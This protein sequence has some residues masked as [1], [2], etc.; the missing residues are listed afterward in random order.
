MKK[1]LGKRIISGVTSVLLGLSAF[2]QAVPLSET[3]LLRARAV[4]ENPDGLPTLTVPYENSIWYR[5]GPLGVA[6]DFHYFAFD[7]VS[8]APHTNGNFAAKHVLGGEG[9]PNQYIGQIVSVV[10]ESWTNIGNEA[11]LKNVPDVVIPVDYQAYGASDVKL[12]Y[13]TQRY[14]F[15]IYRPDETNFT[16]SNGDRDASIE[17]SY[18]SHYSTDFMDFDKLRNYYRDLSQNY[19]SKEDNVES[20]TTDDKG[21]LV[22]KLNPSGENVVNLSAEDF[23]KLENN[24]IHIEGINASSGDS[25]TGTVSQIKDNQYLIMNIDM[26]SFKGN[27][28]ILSKLS[29][30]MKR[31]TID[32]PNSDMGANG[33]E[34]FYQGTNILVNL[35]N[36][37][38]LNNGEP[39]LTVTVGNG[40]FQTLAPDIHLRMNCTNGNGIAEDITNAGETHMNFFMNPVSKNPETSEIT[41][42]TVEKEW[43]DDGKEHGDKDAVTVTLYRSDEPNADLSSL[44]DSSALVT[45][46][47]EAFEAMVGD[48]ALVKDNTVVG[49]GFGPGFGGGFGGGQSLPSISVLGLQTSGTSIGEYDANKNVLMNDRT[50]GYGLYPFEDYSISAVETAY[51]G[52]GWDAELV[53]KAYHDLI[54]LDE[55]NG[56]IY[57]NKLDYDLSQTYNNTIWVCLPVYSGWFADYS[58]G[59]KATITE[60]TDADGNTIRKITKINGEPG[61]VMKIG[62]AV[63]DTKN[64]WQNTWND[65]PA[66]SATGT[67]Y[68][69]YAIE[70]TVKKDYTVSYKGNSMPGGADGTIIVVNTKEE[71]HPPAGPSEI[72]IKKTD[73][74]GTNEVEGAEFKLTISGNEPKNF[75]GVK[76][77]TVDGKGKTELTFS[78]SQTIKGLKDGTYVLE[79]KV[80]PDGYTVVSKF[81][82][83]LSEGKVTDTSAVTSGDV[84]IADDGKTLIVLDDISRVTISKVDIADGENELP[85]AKLT[86][87]GESDITEEM[88]SA[89]FT[90][91][92]SVDSM[93]EGQ[94]IIE[95][96]NL[97]WIS[98]E[99]KK[100]ELSKLPDGAYSLSE[101]IA[102]E[103]YL[104][105]G[106]ESWEFK[107]E[108]GIVSGDSKTYENGTYVNIDGENIIVVG[109]KTEETD[110]PVEP[111]TVTIS[112]KD[113]AGDG[114]AE[115]PNAK[116]ELLSKDGKDLSDVTA[117]QGDEEVL[118]RRNENNTSVVYTSGTNSTELS[119]LPDGNYI[120][121]ETAAPNG[122]MAIS[123][124]EFTIENGE[125]V[126]NGVATTTGEV[127]VDGN[128]ITVLDK[129]TTAT[130]SK[131]EM[132]GGD[133]L[134]GA[135]LEIKSLDGTELS[136][137]TAK[138]GEKEVALE[139]GKKTE[140]DTEVE[141]KT[142]IRYVSGTE[143]TVLTQLPAGKYALTEYTAPNGY[144]KAETIEF[145][146]LP[147]GKVQVANGT[148]DNGNTIYV[149]AEEVLMEDKPIEITI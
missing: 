97:T 19:G 119:N 23:E 79:E 125:V 14:E 35:I 111:K 138:Q 41:N 33:E 82:F 77:G 113:M 83:T 8:V 75:D 58:N 72:L 88:I 49:G 129:A 32:N 10:G 44:T 11:K 47:K 114:T 126:A 94:Y 15:K 13:P 37:P 45:F 136:E 148:D 106:G 145:V 92:D 56:I 140:N 135:T 100:M 76:V 110:T 5:G 74:S 134:P 52:F 50:Y 73:M 2:T 85:N 25:N 21:N 116:F 78:G 108:N 131:I 115:L 104:P 93:T 124:F 86:L 30:D 137:V 46:Y 89:D 112:K 121:R 139:F 3:G 24:N 84:T 67:R 51:E 7:T 109:D 143:K 117:K 31:F 42:I 63:L 66:Q 18:V 1:T 57:F 40:V 53:F 90:K 29:A 96:G 98:A 55:E 80:A 99:N 68:Y 28:V 60:E 4:E 38:A 132:G 149:D 102:P 69:Y 6:G 95:N 70:D 107:L 54:S 16:I 64:N 26:S 65:L 71:P 34:T 127:K 9:Y 59:F 146:V 43:D 62:S 20:K 144:L 36:A 27:D 130:I 87:D 101:I 120:L 141:D 123:N 61:E 91:A 133:E 48:S 105:I 128:N 12:D 103:G 147:D 17:Y 39:Q 22:I 118:L 122:F 81:T 142:V